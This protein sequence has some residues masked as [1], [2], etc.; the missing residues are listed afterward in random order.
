M[1]IT[2]E[3]HPS[4]TITTVILEVLPRDGGQKWLGSMLTSR[5]SKLENVDLQQCLFF[6]SAGIVRT[7]GYCKTEMFPL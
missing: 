4:Q 1:V 6:S 2:N 7:G 5:G 3:A